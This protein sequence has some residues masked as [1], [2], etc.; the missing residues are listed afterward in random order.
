MKYFIGHWT[1]VDVRAEEVE[2][3]ARLAEKILK[4][5]PHARLHCIGEV[6]WEMGINPNA[7][8][9]KAKEAARG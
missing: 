8:F 3:P 4:A 1:G 7:Y 9:I 2:I 6:E 5:Y